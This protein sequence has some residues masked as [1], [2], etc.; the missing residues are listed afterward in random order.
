MVKLMAHPRQGGTATAPRGV[1]GETRADG[2][3][4]PP[5]GARS[6]SPRSDSPQSEGAQSQGGKSQGAK[7]QAPA[8]ARPSTGETGGRDGPDP[9]RYGDWEKNGRCI[10]F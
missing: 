4:P 6:E 1:D 5:A 10:D 8:D 2:A 7:N 9:T 3:K